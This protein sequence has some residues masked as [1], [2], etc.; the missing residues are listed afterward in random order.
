VDLVEACR[1]RGLRAGDGLEMLAQQAA[2]SFALWT[3]MHP[4]VDVA[5]AALLV[6]VRSW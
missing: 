5:R 2:R 6:A 4:S 3:G 1:A